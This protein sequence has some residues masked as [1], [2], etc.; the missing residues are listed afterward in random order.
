MVSALISEVTLSDEEGP[1][2]LN[3]TMRETWTKKKNKNLFCNGCSLSAFPHFAQSKRALGLIPAARL[4]PHQFQD[5]Q[6]IALSTAFDFLEMLPVEAGFEI[7]FF[8]FLNEKGG[9]SFWLHMKFFKAESIISDAAAEQ[10]PC[11]QKADQ[12]DACLIG[13][14]ARDKIWNSMLNSSKQ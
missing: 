7:L 14:L 8:F 4:A 9:A 6:E 13:M 12:R 2:F 11:D 3:C 5:K 1:W 10:I